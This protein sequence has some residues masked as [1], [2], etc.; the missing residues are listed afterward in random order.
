VDVT[1]TKKKRSSGSDHRVPLN[2]QSAPSQVANADSPQ[3][4]TAYLMR[5]L[6]RRDKEVKVLETESAA[7]QE[8]TDVFNH[9]NLLRS[10]ALISLVI[11]LTSLLTLR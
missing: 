6:S 1:P 4:F 3:T 8:K 10:A 9:T 5:R 7:F 11:C 2:Q